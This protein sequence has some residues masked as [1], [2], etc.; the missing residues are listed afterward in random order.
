MKRYFTLL[1]ACVFYLQLFAQEG[2][3]IPRAPEVL[4]VPE[5]S[6]VPEVPEVPETPEVSEA[7]AYGDTVNV[8]NRVEVIET[9]ET[10]R[11][12]VGQNEVVIVE[13]NGDTV[14]VK[15]GNRGV[16]IVE[17][18]N[19]TEIK[20][21]DMDDFPSS[22]HK[23]K[24]KKKRFRPHYAGIELG[25]ANYLTPDNSLTLPPEDSYMDLN[26]G[27]SYTLGINVVDVGVGF[28]TDKIGLVSGLGFEFTNYNFNGQNSIR[29]D[30][31]TGVIGEFVPNYAGNITKSKMTMWYI[32]VP[33][34]IEFQIPAGRKR[35]NLSMGVVGG[36]KLFSR[37]KMKYVEA[38]SKSKEVSR[39]DYN[40]YPLRWGTTARVGYGFMHLY[41][42]YYPTSLFKK[43][44]G[45][46]LYPLNVGLFFAF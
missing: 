46:V 41:A 44:L 19:G 8:M 38:G 30:P 31:V 21:L 1:I 22:S 29:K 24:H 3:T 6:E 45:P 9:P 36:L 14:K 37:T 43:D 28:G 20:V 11:V 16:S 18:P 13:E 33:L 27:R 5:V 4:A 15:L 10:T 7:P 12:T 34:L 32:N 2:D 25:L 23:N 17:G 35:V 42:T 26:T 39:G 40:L